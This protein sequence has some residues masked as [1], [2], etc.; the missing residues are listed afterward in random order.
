MKKSAPGFFELFTQKCKTASE[1]DVWE[2]QPFVRLSKREKLFLVILLCTAGVLLY[3]GWRLFWFLTDDAYISFRYVSN[4]ILGYGYVWNPPPFRPVE[5]YTN[6]LWIVVLDAV[7]RVFNVAPPQSA[8]YLSLFFSFSTLVLGAFMVLRIHWN[9]SLR[10]Y[11]MIFLGMVLLGITTNRTFL[12]WSSSGLET[13]MFNF[14]ITLWI[15]SCIFIHQSSKRWIFFTALSAAL[16]SLTRPDGLLLV[17]A[18]VLMLGLTFL[19][20]KHKLDLK[21]FLL[22]SPLLLIVLHLIWR[23]NFYGQWLPNAYYAKHVA[24]WPQAGLRYGLSFILE[25]ALWI[26][27]ALLL[28]VLITKFPDILKTARAGFSNLIAIG[29]DKNYEHRTDPLITLVASSTLIAH[30]LY[31]TF[32]I[33]GDHFEYRVYSHLILFIFI[34]FIWLLN[35]VKLKAYISITSLAIFILLSYPVP[36]TH[37][38]LTHRIGTESIDKPTKYVP[39]SDHWPRFV[40]WYGKAFDS[41]QLWLIEGHYVCVRHHQHKVFH[42]W[43]ISRFPSREQG[44]SVPADGYPVMVQFGVGVAGWALPRINIIDVSG[45]N[46]FVIARTPHDP[47]SPRHIAHD[48]KPPDGYVESFMPNVW[49]TGMKRIKIGQRK[50]PLTKENIIESEQGWAEKIKKL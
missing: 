49:L 29:S 12:A 16:T 18:T 48:R 30:T 9:S 43:Q 22:A 15:Y 2:G 7:W 6:F 32:I 39:I 35:K 20:Q 44:I 38:L 4:S 26:W 14:F 19:K 31:Y 41:L 11:L 24:P 21:S 37:W 42:L 34:S 13:A 47:N 5:G 3:F 50:V 1:P 10:P 36:W 25:Y 28:F 45:L 46:D 40:S 33:G 23:I 8:N 27:L 17:A